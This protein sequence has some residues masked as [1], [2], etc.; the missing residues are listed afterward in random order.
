M[1]RR[2]ASGT[3]RHAPT[4]AR[5]NAPMPAL[6]PA[7]SLARAAAAA[8]A[9]LFVCAAPAAAQAPRAQWTLL[10]YLAADND[11]EAAQVQDL[12]EMLAVGSTGD[13]NVLVLADRHP[14]GVGKYSND[15]IAELRFARVADL[16]H[17]VDD[18]VVAEIENWQAVFGGKHITVPV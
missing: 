9:L 16:A 6:A 4:A 11:L 2:T 18:D 13:V 14:G 10:F 17:A 15:A 7:H 12:R 3:T 1:R 5:A 8:L